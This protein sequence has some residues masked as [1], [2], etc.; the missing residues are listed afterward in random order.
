MDKL[1]NIFM[2]A[3]LLKWDK[4]LVWILEWAN[5]KCHII[6]PTTTSPTQIWWLSKWCFCRAAVDNND[7]ATKTYLTHNH[8]INPSRPTIAASCLKLILDMAHMLI[9]DSIHRCEPKTHFMWLIWVILHFF[10]YSFILFFWSP[11]CFAVHA[12]DLGVVGLGR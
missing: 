11:F 9:S 6:S 2:F 10:S 12:T 1:W 8:N 3:C 4:E 7:V 5:H